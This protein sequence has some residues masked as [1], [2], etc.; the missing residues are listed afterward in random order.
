MKNKT[1]LLV[2]SFA[3]VASL[4]TMASK[5]NISFFGQGRMSSLLRGDGFNG[6]MEQFDSTSGSEVM[7]KNAEPARDMAYGGVMM[8][9]S[10]IAEPLPTDSMPIDLK[11]MPPYYGDD[12]LDVQDRVY[13][14]S[15]YHV[16]IVDDV[17]AYLRGMKE[18]ILSIG[19]V[20]LNSGVSA[21]DGSNNTYNSGSLYVKVPVNKFDEVTGRVTENVEKVFSESINASDVTGQ[22]VGTTETLQDLK[23]QKSLKEAALSEA[24]SEVEKRRY[25]I[26]ISRLDQQIAVAEK[27]LDNVEAQV[28]YSSV[29]IEASDSERYY[30][31]DAD[32]GFKEEFMKAWESVKEVIKVALY[33][34]IWVFVY[35]IVWLPIVIVIKKLFRKFGN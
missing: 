11:M 34:G 2:L 23:D 25:Q 3:V 27:S 18:Y 5:S 33:F 6:T 17:Q 1:L 9:S 15:S 31:P 35:S 19:G 4:L 21:G 14:K 30:N 22:L 7:Y 26:E 28:E 29:S 32:V 10:I 16:V 24:K 20:V 13:Q 12:A 8:D